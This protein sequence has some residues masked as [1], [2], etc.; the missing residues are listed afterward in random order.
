MSLQDYFTIGYL[1]FYTV[2]ILFSISLVAYV[3]GQ[4]E[5]LMDM[6]PFEEAINTI[7]Y[8]DYAS[9]GVV[10]GGTLSSVFLASRVSSNPLFLPVGFVLLVFSSFVAYIIS[11]VPEEM[12]SANSVV[13]SVFAGLPVSSLVVGNLH[14]FVFVSGLLG[15]ISVYALSNSP[16]AGRGGGRRAPIQ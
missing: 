4:S 1:S 16:N 13:E 7:Q 14:V 15:M 12:S 2:M 3:L 5:F 11:L 8:L 10:V 9:L 6:E